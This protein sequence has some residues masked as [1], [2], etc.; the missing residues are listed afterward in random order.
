MMPDISDPKLTDLGPES[1]GGTPAD[2]GES[3]CA[4]DEP[5]TEPLQVCASQKAEQ[6]PS[7]KFPHAG[8]C[9]GQ[10]VCVLKMSTLKRCIKQTHVMHGLH[11][12]QSRCT[13]VCKTPSMKQL[14]GPRINL[15]P[16]LHVQMLGM[17]DEGFR[18][19]GRKTEKGMDSHG[20]TCMCIKCQ[21]AAQGPSCG[22]YACSPY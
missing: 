7:Q 20:R 1:S 8:A 3:S 17:E 11:M 4:A 14:Q 19:V 12:L 21:R 13:A 16:I 2:K 5:F 15:T 18:F 9:N 6:I 22:C 10:S